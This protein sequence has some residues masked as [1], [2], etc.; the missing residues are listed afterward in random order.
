MCIGKLV[1]CLDTSECV[2]GCGRSIEHRLQNGAVVDAACL[3]LGDVLKQIGFHVIQ[4]IQGVGQILGILRKLLLTL[5]F[6]LVCTPLTDAR[7]TAD[8]DDGGTDKTQGNAYNLSFIH[9]Y[10]ALSSPVACAVRYAVIKPSISPSM[11]ASML[12]FSNPVR[13]SLAS[14]YGIKT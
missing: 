12:L 3:L 8:A 11:T 14:V 4:L 10:L 1:R 5:Y 6:R 7:H 9:G 2:D 13:V